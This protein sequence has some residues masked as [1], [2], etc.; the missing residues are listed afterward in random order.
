MGLGRVRIK[1]EFPE[2]FIY[3]IFETNF[4]FYVK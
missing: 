1:K 2:T 3:K 4:S